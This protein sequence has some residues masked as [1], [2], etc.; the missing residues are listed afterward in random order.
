M[1][2][3][4]PC[5]APAA[6]HV[7]HQPLSS[8]EFDLSKLFSCSGWLK[9][10][11]ETLCSLALNVITHDCNVFLCL[12]PSSVCFAFGYESQFCTLPELRECCLLGQFV[13]Y[14]DQE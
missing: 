13:P 2:F 11:I 5:V 14:H 4:S 8:K 1:P 9:D 10:K 7:P 12:L 6:C 3:E